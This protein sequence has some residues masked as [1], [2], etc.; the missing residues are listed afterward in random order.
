HDGTPFC[1]R[2]DCNR[3]M[4]Y[5]LFDGL[6][7]LSGIGWVIVGGESG[8][9]ARPMAIEWAERLVDECMRAGVPTFMKQMGKVTVTE[10]RPGL[11]PGTWG[12]S[13]PWDDAAGFT[14]E[15]RTDR[16]PF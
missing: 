12:W 6:P 3:E 4:Q 2:P 15:R 10:Q 16:G 9:K 14:V 11:E 5:L 1:A 13:F 8:H 7:D